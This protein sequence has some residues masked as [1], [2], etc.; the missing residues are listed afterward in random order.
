MTHDLD[1]RIRSITA[2]ASDAA[3]S[4][5]DTEYFMSRLGRRRQ[6]HRAL[7]IAILATATITVGATLVVVANRD[8]S[9][10]NSTNAETSSNEPPRVDPSL[11]Q[12]LN[13]YLWAVVGIEGQ[14][15]G[16]LVA[17][18]PVADGLGLP[19]SAGAD[20]A[21]VVGVA[22]STLVVSVVTD[23]ALAATLRSAAK[24]AV[25]LASGAIAI[26]GIDSDY[27]KLIQVIDGD[28]VVRL[29]SDSTQWVH[30]LDLLEAIG[31]DVA[32]AWTQPLDTVGSQASNPTSTG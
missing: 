2:R 27:E 9:S 5:P 8:K 21:I 13:G 16:W 3:P 24:N 25:T 23:N 6:P 29:H 20:A 31:A 19:E 26:V 32:A 1:D 15:A 11:Y 7:R 14:R 22:P 10:S 30:S 4:P 12:T 18:I 17:D 28:V